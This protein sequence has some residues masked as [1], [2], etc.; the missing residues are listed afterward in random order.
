MVH[1]YV[2]MGIST[3]TFDIAKIYVALK[4]SP[5]Y[6]DHQDF[7][8]KYSLKSYHGFNKQYV[9][10]IPMVHFYPIPYIHTPIKKY[11]FFVNGKEYI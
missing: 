2:C 6:Y 7:F 11:Q 4:S 10:S 3:Y 9:L 5:L 8:Q 1:A